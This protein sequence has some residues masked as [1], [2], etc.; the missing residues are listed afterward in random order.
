MEAF[1]DTV[2]LWMPRLG[3]G[4]LYAIDAKVQFIIMRFDLA[5]VFRAPIRQDADRV[6]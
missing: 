1:A 2:R 6:P 5:A 3:L 4:V